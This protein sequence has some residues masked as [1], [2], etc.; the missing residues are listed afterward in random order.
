MSKHDPT[1]PDEEV[2]AHLLKEAL[3]TGAAAATMLA[4]PGAAQGA[5][6]PTAPEPSGSPSQ[7]IPVPDV[8]SNAKAAPSRKATVKRHHKIFRHKA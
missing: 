5:T 8:G 3:A 1:S 4:V 6:A 2:E 7:V